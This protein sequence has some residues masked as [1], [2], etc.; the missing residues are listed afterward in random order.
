MEDGSAF[1][2]LIR[3][4]STERGGSSIKSPLECEHVS[5]KG[6]IRSPVEVNNIE[7]LQ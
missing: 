6:L 4:A 5:N 2:Q 7:N 1:V 3:A